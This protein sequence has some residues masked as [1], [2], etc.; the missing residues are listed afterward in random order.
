MSQRQ[1]PES[2]ENQAVSIAEKVR[3]W[4][5]QDRINQ[6]LIPR[7][8]RQSE[9]LTGHMADHENLPLAAVEV[10]RQAISPGPG[11]DPKAAARSPAGERGTGP[12]P[13]PSKSRT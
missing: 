4:E 12:E 10:A 5:E 3:F 13:Q 2:E 8:I 7:V 6:E 11:D 1:T 9:L